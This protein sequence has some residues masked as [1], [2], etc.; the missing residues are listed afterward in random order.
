MSKSP[1]EEKILE[2]LRLLH[3]EEA[4]LYEILKEVKA[5]KKEEK[6]EK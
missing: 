4:I 1:Y 5:Q 3:A 6:G 2:K